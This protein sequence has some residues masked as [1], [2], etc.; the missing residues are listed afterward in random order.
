MIEAMPHWTHNRGIEGFEKCLRVE[1]N[2]DLSTGFFVAV[3]QQFKKEDLFVLYWRGL[4]GNLGLQ[5][6]ELGGRFGGLSRPRSSEADVAK[7]S[8]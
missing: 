7:Q 1:P 2:T 4:V 6:T 5:T 8:H 3:F